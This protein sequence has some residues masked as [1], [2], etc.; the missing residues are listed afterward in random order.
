MF[1]SISWKTFVNLRRN[2]KFFRPVPKSYD[3]RV[4]VGS[5][6]VKIYNCK[7]CSSTLVG[8]LDIPFSALSLRN[9]FSQLYKC[10]YSPPVST[11]NLFLFIVGNLIIKSEA[12]ENNFSLKRDILNC[13]KKQTKKSR[14]R[15][16]GFSP[17]I[18]YL[19][20]QVS[21]NE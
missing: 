8:L 18:S 10:I 15:W 16:S 5:T 20:S 13:I 14:F 12:G 11:D 21:V 4:G 6:S 3:A 1:K 9:S 7:K 19:T 2:P 17:W